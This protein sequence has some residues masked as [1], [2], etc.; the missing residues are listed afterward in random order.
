MKY[1]YRVEF[2]KIGGDKSFVFRLPDELKVV[3]IFMNSDIQSEYVSKKFKDYCTQVQ[4]GKLK[5]KSF[6]GDICSTTITPDYVQIVLN[7]GE[8]NNVTSIETSELILLIEAFV[9]ERKK[10]TI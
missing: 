4:N 5:E 9:N 6:S 1:N 10:H 7:Y 8:E 2:L 3:E